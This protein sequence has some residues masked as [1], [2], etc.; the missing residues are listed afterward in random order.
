M[1]E[2][3]IWVSYDVSKPGALEAQLLKY[4]EQRFHANHTRTWTKRKWAKPN[5]PST[6]VT[7]AIGEGKCTFTLPIHPE[8]AA[9]S[10]R[11]VAA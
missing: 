3:A 4:C 8:N 1:S 6:D 7:I 10:V 9:P 5:G 2:E 11:V